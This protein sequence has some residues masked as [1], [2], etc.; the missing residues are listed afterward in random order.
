MIDS[1]TRLLAGIGQGSLVAVFL[2]AL[3]A[4]ALLADGTRRR[5]RGPG[6]AAGRAEREIR[7]GRVALMVVAA[8]ALLSAAGLVG[9]LLTDNFAFAYV[10]AHSSRDL[11]AVYKVGAL[12]GGQEGSLLFWLTIL[13]LYA[14]SIAWR[15]R[16]RSA[17]L[18]L[19]VMGVTE[20]FFSFLVAFVASPFA[21]LPPDRVPPDGNGLSPLLRDPAM[22]M[23]PVALYTGFVG[24]SVP[25]AF[26]VA[27]LILREPGARW[28]RLTR[29]WALLA[30]GVLGLGLLL[31]AW[32]SY[33]VLGWGGY[34]GWDPVENAALMP[35]LVGTA[36][37][38]SALVQERRG[39]LKAWNMVLVMAAY[40]LTIL[41][42]TL[43]RSGLLV[44]V[45]AFAQS[46]IA[47]YF[48]VFLGLALAGCLYLLGVRWDDLRDE[49]PGVETLVNKET[50]FL[51]NNV[52][53]LVTAL[54][55]LV[56]T[57]LPEITGLF[58]LRLTV[59]A[60]Y[61]EQTAGPLLGLLLVLMGLGPLV[62][63][64]QSDGRR[65]R[66]K[67]L[68]PVLSAVV[69]AA[70]LVAA[71]VM[72]GFI[73]FGVAAALFVMAS[74]FLEVADG[75]RAR[76]S[77]TGEP[78]LLSLWRLFDRN[79]SRYGGYVAHLGIALMALAVIGSTAYQQHLSLTLRPGQSALV[80]PYTVTFAGLRQGLD[81]VV[82]V[83]R[84]EV[85]VRQGGRF[86][87]TLTPAT[88]FYQDSREGPISRAAIRHSFGDD[89]YV[90]LAGWDAS[91]Q[92]G[93]EV[94]VNPLVNWLWVGGLLLLLGTGFALWPRPS[95]RLAAVEPERERV[96]G[97]LRELEY[98]YR[99][100]KV[101]GETYARLRGE[102]ERQAR[103]AL[104][105]ARERERRRREVEEGLLG[106]RQP[107]APSGTVDHPDAGHPAPE[108]VR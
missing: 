103:R 93:L 3:A 39:L 98:D 91:G 88:L 61:F 27:A 65:L 9:L 81:G 18:A 99:M 72:G 31:G 14:A 45:H 108:V 76:R 22:L 38:H 7:A 36:F 87:G 70:V 56:G 82:P 55:V 100:A 107:A 66:R 58:G 24:F 50:A 1:V 44:S 89:L 11:P 96:F 73:A 71:G 59:G 95:A 43:T 42:T 29:R 28:I 10:T 57:L 69:V 90:V 79:P 106:G 17:P 46:P 19:A 80:G 6:E 83:V 77:M 20:L 75:Y 60:P 21:L 40:L 49:Q 23:H 34:W 37:I 104:E 32:W 63:W 51:A 8:L 47:P 78:P 25:F 101:D 13:A 2:L 30:W 15:S 12:W 85:E 64:R 105:E 62:A 86:L 92:A 26:G 16:E 4:V 102:Y 67:L 48:I 53:L 52:V 94:Y 97:L 33:H 54:V 41:G 68:L 35:W 84:G 74:V 5:E